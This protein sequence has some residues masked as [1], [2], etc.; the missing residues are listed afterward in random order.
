MMPWLAFL[1]LASAAEPDADAIRT[2]PARI[3]VGAE[4]IVCAGETCLEL[5]GRDVSDGPTFVP[6]D[7]V[8]E[9]GHPYVLEKAFL[10][11][12]DQCNKSAE[13]RLSFDPERLVPQV[14]RSIRQEM[15]QDAHVELL[16]GIP[17]ESGPDQ[18]HT[19]CEDGICV[20]LAIP[21]DQLTTWVVP[22]ARPYVDLGPRPADD[23]TGDRVPEGHEFFLSSWSRLSTLP[24]GDAVLAR[25]A[26]DTAIDAYD[27]TPKLADMPDF[28][29]HMPGPD[30]RSAQLVRWEGDQGLVRLQ[31]SHMEVQG[32][33]PAVEVPPPNN[34]FGFH[35]TGGHIDCPGYSWPLL[36]FEDTWVIPIGT[37]L[38]DPATHYIVGTT[39]KPVA[40]TAPSGS[41]RLVDI[42]VKTRWGTFPLAVSRKDLEPARA[43][44]TEELQK[45][46]RKT[47]R[48]EHRTP[49]GQCRAYTVKRTGPWT[50]DLIADAPGDLR[51]QMRWVFGL[52]LHLDEDRTWVE[53]PT[54]S[55]DAIEGEVTSAQRCEGPDCDHLGEGWRITETPCEE[56]R[57]T[58]AEPLPL[59]GPRVR[60]G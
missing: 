43:P 33:L 23:F 13:L 40:L 16:P 37:P 31:T 54:A 17:W 48:L 51:R 14:A 34:G 3:V 44:Y 29:D 52:P 21:A 36:P 55:R 30:L 4:A 20:T 22:Q 60:G 8:S 11:L 53:L 35:T 41:R 15:G 45:R 58:E 19:F 47:P 7:G 1:A 38:V 18:P 32:W 12:P 49:D 6:I 50:A 9:D 56:E 26:D 46:L 10:P 59:R 25:P 2:Y 24:G 39:T 57:S 27:D 42:S 28:H 5:T